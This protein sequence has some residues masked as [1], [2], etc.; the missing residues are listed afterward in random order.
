LHELA[1]L[2]FCR[3]DKLIRH[4]FFRDREAAITYVDMLE[5]LHQD[6]TR[7]DIAWLLGIDADVMS[8]DVRLVEVRN[9]VRNLVLPSMR[10]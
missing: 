10:R 3:I 6:P 2:T 5:S 7:K 9:W 1:R 8:E 4:G